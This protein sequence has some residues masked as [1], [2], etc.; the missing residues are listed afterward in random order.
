MLLAAE[1]VLVFFE[2]L[3][4]AND[5]A[6]TMGNCFLQLAQTGGLRYSSRGR[7]RYGTIRDDWANE[8]RS[9]VDA[10]SQYTNHWSHGEG[11]Q[12]VVGHS[13]RDVVVGLSRS[14]PSGSGTRRSLLQRGSGDL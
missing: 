4:I 8:K 9:E 1:E 2:V 10:V 11:S 12:L 5:L 3:S 14:S 6:K 7:L 13:V